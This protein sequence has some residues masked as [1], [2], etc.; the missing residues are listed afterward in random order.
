M[1]MLHII[2]AYTTKSLL[3]TFVFLSVFVS[4]VFIFTSIAS[5]EETLFETYPSNPV[6]SYS[7]IPGSFDENQMRGATVLYHDGVYWMYYTALGSDN[8]MTIGLAT[9]TDGVEWTRYSSTPIFRCGDNSLN[10]CTGSG[11]WSA[12]R[13]M[14]PSIIFDEG[15]Y[16]MWYSGDPE[17]G[18]SQLAAGYATSSDGIVWDAY[19]M[20]P[21]F[22]GTQLGTIPDNGFLMR[23][24]TK[25]EE[26]YYMYYYKFTTSGAN[27]YAASSSDGINWQEENDHQPVL[28]G[29]DATYLGTHEGTVYFTNNNLLYTSDDG[30]TF[31]LV[32][33]T[34]LTDD[35]LLDPD[36]GTMLVQD[37]I[38]HM[39]RS[40]FVG[41]INWGGA[42]SVIT[43]YTAPLS[44]LVVSPEVNNPP[45]LSFIGNQSTP[46]NQ[47]LS[48]TISA[49]DPDGDT[50][51]YAAA[52]LP[53]GAAFNPETRT[54]S[55]TPDYDDAGNYENVEFSVMDNGS[56]MEVDA[57]LIT[58]TVGDI[59]RAPVILSPGAQELLEEETLQ[60]TVSAIDPDSDSFSLAASNLPQ[61][62]TF[63]P[64][65]GLFTWTPSLSQEGIYT[66][67]FTA[68]DT[69]T[70]SEAGVI[71]VVVTVGDNPTPV[72]QSEDI[73]E[74]VIDL[75]L[76]T[77]SEN[78]Y[79]A[80]LQ[81]VA[82]FI[83]QGKI[84]AAINQLNAFINKVNQD[85]T[86]NILTEAQRD[87]L[88]DAA[89]DL[90]DDLN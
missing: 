15:I 73:I 42:N 47:T 25:L 72:E 90:I 78:S 49:S 52:N 36:N 84:Q 64:Q 8:S 22:P 75:G 67:T 41:N 37:G 53:A 59:N 33:A 68:T 86:Q 81:K 32:S 85:Y 7:A 12:Y 89:E 9:S 17:N 48:F 83:E 60:F 63:D 76:P 74:D 70:P 21:I 55:W 88:V 31:E 39:W 23:G 43:Y 56:P 40:K 11:G 57:E 38:V 69:G 2:H 30:I 3:K 45:V 27:M 79:M 1:D 62:A 4:A 50:L 34:P 14:Y 20:N 13:V 66:V 82:G 87:D 58:I 80:N 10:T 54:F 46:E 19:N 71:D 16:K 6:L 24:V 26:T 29:G 77:N 18:P 44:I 65:T 61:G 5:A 28:S 35:P 51:T